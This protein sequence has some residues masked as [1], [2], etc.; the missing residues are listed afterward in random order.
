[1]RFDEI[2]YWSELKLE[3]IKKYAQAYS[4][5]LAA[6]QR[7]RLKHVYIDG[8]SGAGEHVSKGTGEMV[9]G[10]PLNALH[11]VP[12]FVEYFLVDLNG[13]KVEH[14]R[15][16]VG[17]RPDI[18]VLHGDCNAVL[19]DQVFPNVRWDQYRRGL[20]LLDPYGLHLD[21]QV[22][23]TAAKMKS[24]EIFLNFPVHDIN[25]NVLRHNVDKVTQ[26]HRDRM[27]RYWGDESWATELYREAEQRSLFGDLDREK[28][29]NDAV[30][31]VFR[32]RLRT[33]AGFA[34]VPKPLPMRN[35]KGCVVY[36]LYFASQKPVAGKIVDDIF[37]TYRDRMS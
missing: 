8:F 3:I 30:A 10:S 6:Q 19:L 15:S 25:R 32:Q 11:V 16:L 21:W 27:T 14:L 18:H 22:I 23:D 28:Q 2:G 35:S 1:M 36:Y 33:V 29:Q 13:K 9:P 37:A 4:T 31:E 20:C 5:I 24:I 34:H 26:E 17:D 12:P 7:P